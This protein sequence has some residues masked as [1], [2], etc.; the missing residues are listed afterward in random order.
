MRLF[1]KKNKENLVEKLD[2]ISI[3]KTDKEPEI[4]LDDKTVTKIKEIAAMSKESHVF[5]K[6]QMSELFD[7]NEQLCEIVEYLLPLA[8]KGQNNNS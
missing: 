2:E 5:F 6:D 4:K 3:E 8:E 1:N 7:L